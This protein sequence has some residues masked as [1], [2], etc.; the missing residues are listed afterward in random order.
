MGFETQPCALPRRNFFQDFRLLGQKAEGLSGADISVVVRDALM[1]P[2]RKVQTATHFKLISGPSRANP[3]VILH[4]LLTPCSPGDPG[5]IEKNWMDVPGDKLSEPVVR[6]RTSYD[7]VVLSRVSDVNLE[8]CVKISLA[9]RLNLD[10]FQM[11][12]KDMLLSL[13]QSKP[14]VNEKDLD[15][16][17]AFMNDFGQE[18]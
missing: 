8:A 6:N 13:S 7:H 10:Q 5:A 16:L 11:T 1:Q 14:T 2:V 15:N 17:K 9:L 3:E 4:D 18:G 12:M